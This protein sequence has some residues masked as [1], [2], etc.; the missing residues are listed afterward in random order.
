MTISNGYLTRD[1]FKAA[2]SI[3]AVGQ[4][5]FI[6]ECIETASRDVD[7][8]CGRRFFLD[9]AATQRF[10][11][12]DDLT[13][14]SIDDASDTTGFILQY[15]YDAINFTTVA[16]ANYETV[17]NNQIGP[18]GQTGWPITQLLLISTWFPLPRYMWA[19]RSTVA[20]TAK[21]GWLTVPTPVKT[22][23]RRLAQMQFEARNAPF[24]MAGIGD[25]GIVRVKQD[26]LATQLLEPY[27]SRA[28]ALA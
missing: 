19:R 13:S 22:A 21:W 16:A 14:V 4:D 15:T 25:L 2:L 9:A 7:A 18:N 3:I 5:T 24:G 23:T 26:S 12:P 20:V 17:P 10:Y 1:E 28:P 8:Y 6:D 11:M 27:V